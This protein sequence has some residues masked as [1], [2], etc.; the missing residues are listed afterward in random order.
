[1]ELKGATGAYSS[2]VP[3]HTPSLSPYRYPD[4]SLVCGKPDFMTISGIDVLTNPILIVEVLSP[5]TEH[6]DKELKRGAYQ[7]IPSLVEYL[8]IS[9]DAPHV[10]HYV[11]HAG[12]WRRKDFADLMVHIELPS[13]TTHVLIADIYDGVTFD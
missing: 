1:M 13:T 5:E 8:I 7:K 3:V 11:N 6:L 10:I 9:Q 2:A 4:A 12:D